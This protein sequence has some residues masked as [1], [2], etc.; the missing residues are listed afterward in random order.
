M[1]PCHP[2]CE[3]KPLLCGFQGL[4]LLRSITLKH[5]HLSYV[6]DLGPPF[7]HWLTH[8]RNHPYPAAPI[9]CIL[10]FPLSLS[11]SLWLI[12]NSILIY[13]FSPKIC[14]GRSQ[15]LSDPVPPHPAM[16][17]PLHCLSSSPVTPCHIL[18]SVADL[19]NHLK[20]PLTNI[21]FCNSESQIFWFLK[22]S[23]DICS[24]FSLRLWHLSFNLPNNW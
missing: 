5:I 20:F 23:L 18:S 24:L 13:P 21:F 4:P 19:Q 6:S 17:P 10:L 11:V 2:L 12:L 9:F 14:F 7:L 1:V 16:F 3:V 22:V 15:Y 8:L